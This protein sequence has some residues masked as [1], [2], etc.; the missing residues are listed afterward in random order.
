L[1]KL[2]TAHRVFFREVASLAETPEK[3]RK[4]LGQ[5][6][7]VV[8]FLRLQ[9]DFR[10]ELLDIIRPYEQLSFEKKDEEHRGPL[11]Q[12]LSE[13][14]DEDFPMLRNQVLRADDPLEWM[15]ILI[16]VAGVLVRTG[17][18]RLDVMRLLATYE[19]AGTIEQDFEPVHV[20]DKAVL[21]DQ[22]EARKERMR[23][24]FV[25]TLLSK[26]VKINPTC[27]F[28][29][30]EKTDLHQIWDLYEQRA[31]GEGF[32]SAVFLE[33]VES[34]GIP[35]YKAG[36]DSLDYLKEHSEVYGYYY[37]LSVD[38][39]DPQVFLVVD[40]REGL[41][42]VQCQ[43]EDVNKK[44]EKDSYFNRVLKWFGLR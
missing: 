26:S 36:E 22:D 37:H 13:N 35:F 17:D 14:T 38:M 28:Q 39:N 20:P 1:E 34:F 29:D 15:D 31:E 6:K 5:L 25:R 27:E 33:R 30:P 7:R 23:K 8:G 41:S 19:Q 24:V 11:N 21:V 9:D 32:K 42:V 43:L 16:H 10:K 12:L 44:P 3:E 2:A 18:G 40:A 4:L